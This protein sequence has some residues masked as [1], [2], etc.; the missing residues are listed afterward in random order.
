MLTPT[1]TEIWTEVESWLSL[2]PIAWLLKIVLG[3]IIGL[4][5]LKILFSLLKP[6]VKE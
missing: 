6:H 1:S 2:E 4:V 5:V 3:F